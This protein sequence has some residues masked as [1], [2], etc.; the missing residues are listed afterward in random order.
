M[1]SKIKASHQHQALAQVQLL[2][3][4][5]LQLA[6]NLKSQTMMSQTVKKANLDHQKEV[7]NANLH[8]T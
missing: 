2:R 4:L 5:R 8:C 7:V 1:A 6:V 3:L